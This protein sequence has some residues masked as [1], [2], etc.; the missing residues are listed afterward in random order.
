ML[1]VNQYLPLESK[2]STSILQRL[3]FSSDYHSPATT[4]LQRL[5]FS[6]DYHS[7]AT[8]LLQR[9]PFSSYYHSALPFS[10]HYIS[11]VTT[12]LQSLPFA[13]SIPLVSAFFWC[14]H[15]NEIMTAKGEAW[16]LEMN[17]SR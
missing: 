1:S 6:S 7:P 2:S 15:S 9:L 12:F 17:W 16:V 5:P 8:T 13:V 4:I 11:L 10:G 3:L 14:Q